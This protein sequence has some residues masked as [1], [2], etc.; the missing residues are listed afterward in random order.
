M[1]PLTIASLGIGLVG[2]IGKAL[3]RGAAN[4]E[5]D[6][7]LAKS[8]RYTVNPIAQQRMAYARTLLN[9]RMPS[10]ASMER[11]IMQNQANT[12]GYVQD[13]ST[14]ASVNIA[15]ASAAQGKTNQ[16]LNQLGEMETQDFQRRYGNYENAQQGM[17]NEQDKV[18]QDQTRRYQDE[19]QI[20]GMQNENRQNTWGDIANFG[21]AAANYGMAGGFGGG[22]GAGATGG[23]VPSGSRVSAMSGQMR[24][25]VFNFSNFGNGVGSS[26]SYLNWPS[27]MPQ[28]G[29]KTNH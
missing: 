15:A 17:I 2:T 26:G 20:R 12:M 3:G 19:F 14:D 24:P 5:M 6:A 4:R 10:A 28:I 7:M 29:T 16:S 18:F 8:P 27:S 11:G 22:A 9:A 1:D 25:P 21:M 23:Q 13:N